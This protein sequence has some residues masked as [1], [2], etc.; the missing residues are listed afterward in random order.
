VNRS[1]DK[2]NFQLF[3][4]AQ[5]LTFYKKKHVITKDEICAS[6]AITAHYTT[7]IVP[8]KLDLKIRI[9]QL[10]NSQKST[11]CIFDLSNKKSLY[12]KNISFLPC[13]FLPQ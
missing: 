1:L 6:V 11:F 4:K 13:Y 9:L 8:H 3:I 2:L 12:V 10:N 5:L 7:C